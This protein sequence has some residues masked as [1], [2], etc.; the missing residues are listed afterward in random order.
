MLLI[1][2][3]SASVFLS[4]F[5]YARSLNLNVPNNQAKAVTRLVEAQCNSKLPCGW[6]SIDE[7][8][9]GFRGGIE[10][11]KTFQSFL[12]FYKQGKTKKII[13]NSLGGAAFDGIAIGEI[14]VRDKLH[15]IV[16]GYCMSSC[17]N[18]LFSLAKTKTINGLVAFHGSVTSNQS[19]TPDAWGNLNP[20]RYLAN[21]SLASKERELFKDQLRT[22][23]FISKTG[24]ASSG[25]N[26]WTIY[27]TRELES[28]GFSA[29]NGTVDMNFACFLKTYFEADGNKQKISP[30]SRAVLNHCGQ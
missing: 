24:R 17:A 14:V 19:Q 22:Y 8:T 11:S 4:E 16:D 5:V 28:N 25:I 26:E 15:V 2:I 7:G 6:Y 23:T 30:H 9:I 18:Y 29:I 12:K 20:V 1:S 27:S 13:V 3:Y 10:N 21:L